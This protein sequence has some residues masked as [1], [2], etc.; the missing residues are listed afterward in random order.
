MLVVY[1]ESPGR[2]AEPRNK[3]SSILSEGSE[4]NAAGLNRAIPRWLFLPSV[5]H[6]APV[7]QV[8]R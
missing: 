8:D 7:L 5:T 2:L 3:I 1:S 6:A 4:K